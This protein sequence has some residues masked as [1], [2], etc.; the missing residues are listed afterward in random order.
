VLSAALTGAFLARVTPGLSNEA[1]LL[2]PLAAAGPLPAKELWR[3]GRVSKRAMT[4][5]LKA[6]TRLGLVEAEGTDVALRVELPAVEPASC[7]PL[8]TLVSQLE[9]E[10]PHFP[11][12]YGTADDSFTGG[13]GV[14]WK[15]VPRE[16]T[17]SVDGLP[18]TALLSQALVAFAIDY[19]RA[20]RVAMQWALRLR[21][22]RPAGGM[23]RHGVV[24]ATGAP[25]PR[26]VAMRDAFEPLCT[27][28][29]SR[30]R[31]QHGPTLIDDVIDA[32]R[33]EAVE[34]PPP[35][36]LVSWTGAEFAVLGNG[37]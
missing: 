22:G 15:P 7:M 2:R 9:L 35:F 12:P 31:A 27:E 8:A 23:Q 11:V 32:V 18:M 20:G 36:P 19:E 34:D 21:V 4:T 13:P 30:W 17:S 1:V 5:I 3:H 29:E 16:S 37:S 26:G 10:H 25:T 28:L 24:G 14:D 6:S 33:V